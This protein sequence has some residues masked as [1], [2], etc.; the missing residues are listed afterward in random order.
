MSELL[1]TELVDRNH[2]WR[3]FRWFGDHSYV[4]DHRVVWTIVTVENSSILNMYWKSMW[5]EWDVNIHSIPTFLNVN[6]CNLYGML[7]LSF[8]Q[9]RNLQLLHRPGIE[10]PQLGHW[11]VKYIF[12]RITEYR[13]LPGTCNTGWIVLSDMSFELRWHEFWTSLTV[14]TWYPNIILISYP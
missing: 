9:D 10:A 8:V 3:V 4:I 7:F 1:I 11:G 5:V 14:F 2:Q 12:D 6:S 13:T